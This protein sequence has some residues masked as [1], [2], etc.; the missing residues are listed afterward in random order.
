MNC[1]NTEP[2]FSDHL[3]GT[4]D[5]SST[6]RL[7]AHLRICPNCRPTFLRITQVRKALRTLGATSSPPSFKLNLS[8]RLE[9]ELHRR[10]WAWKP[11]MVWTQALV[12][13]LAILL[14]PETQAGRADATVALDAGTA[15]NQQS[16]EIAREG[17]RARVHPVSF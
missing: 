6:F 1:E 8:N 7:Q 10:R 2:L 16:P 4:L 11:P 9:E 12:A 15:W 5:S 13:A 14:W 17:A 3:D